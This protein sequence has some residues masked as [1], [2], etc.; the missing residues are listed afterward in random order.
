MESTA[1]CLM[2]DRRLLAEYESDRH[3]PYPL[4]RPLRP[5]ELAPF[6]ERDILVTFTAKVPLALVARAENGDLS[7]FIERTWLGDDTIMISP[8]YRAVGA[9]FDD[10][11][12]QFAG[13]VHLQVTC[14]LSKPERP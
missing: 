7:A 2:G 5:D 12:Q 8:E 11:A 10:F 13:Q 4:P 14:Q 6:I 9:T 1:Q 3:V